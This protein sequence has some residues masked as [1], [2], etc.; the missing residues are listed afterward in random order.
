[1]RILLVDDDVDICQLTRKVLEKNGF[2]VDA[3]QDAD[4]ALR[5][6]R[7]QK[8][9][10][11]LMDVMLPGASG[12]EI[13]QSMKKDPLLKEIPVVF[14]TGLVTGREKGLQ[15]EGLAVGGVKYQ[16]LG[17]PYEIEELLRVVRKFSQ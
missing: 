6:A 2:E 17:K 16:T 9:N 15:A 1:M 10:L 5:H 11:I 3:F 14:L 13:V 12:P 4:L 7:G 8:P